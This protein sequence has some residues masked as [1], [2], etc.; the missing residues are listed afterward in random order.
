MRAS[1]RRQDIGRGGRRIARRLA[2]S[3]QL[4]HIDVG[5]AGVAYCY[6]SKRAE[7]RHQ[8]R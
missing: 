8:L 4:H 7:K 2:R 5:T 6:T 1:L 3:Q